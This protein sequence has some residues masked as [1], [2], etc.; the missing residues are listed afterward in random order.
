[1]N[2]IR[3][4]SGFVQNTCLFDKRQSFNTKVLSTCDDSVADLGQTTGSSVP[5]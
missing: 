5:V 3:E 1:M 2:D 4:N